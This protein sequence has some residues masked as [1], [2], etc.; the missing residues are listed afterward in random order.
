MS[1]P[2][3]TSGEPY[4]DPGHNVLPFA[5]HKAPET[6]QREFDELVLAALTSDENAAFVFDRADEL[7]VDFRAVLNGIIESYA[8]YYAVHIHGRPIFYLGE[9]GQMH[10]MNENPDKPKAV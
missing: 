1:T 6:N 9:D 8:D 3:S 7:G 5:A 10:Q 2:E 4:E